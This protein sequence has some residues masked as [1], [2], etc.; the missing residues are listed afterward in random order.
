MTLLPLGGDPVA[1]EG[2]RVVRA[3]DGRAFAV[4]VVDG[5]YVVTDPLCPHNRGPLAEGRVDG[6]VVRCPWHWY[7]FDLATGEC[8]TQPALRLGVYP[9]LR[10]DD[11]WVADVGDEPVAMSMSERLRAHAR[12][13]LPRSHPGTALH[14]GRRP[15]G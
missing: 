6:G 3:D 5:S 4:F 13:E 14:P 12:G 10:R 9:V 1:G 2:A 7:R 8:R 15:H 11:G